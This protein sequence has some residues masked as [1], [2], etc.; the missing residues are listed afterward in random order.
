M[1]FRSKPRVMCSL[2]VDMYASMNKADVFQ[3]MVFTIIKI[4]I[5]QFRQRDGFLR[6]LMIYVW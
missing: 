1:S 3:K 6:S 2:P 5:A 4:E